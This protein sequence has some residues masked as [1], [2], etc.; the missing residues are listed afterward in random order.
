MIDIYVCQ[1]LRAY[2]LSPGYRCTI[3]DKTKDGA[4]RR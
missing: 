2:L 1:I 4:Q 3:S